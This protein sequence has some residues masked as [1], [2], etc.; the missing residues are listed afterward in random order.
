VV[1]P[2]LSCFK[3]ILRIETLSYWGRFCNWRGRQE[4]QRLIALPGEALLAQ[5]QAFLD[6]LL[7]T[8]KV[9][10][11]T[12]LLDAKWKSISIGGVVILLSC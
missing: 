4:P 11:K 9:T 3:A 6:D 10:I 7:R 2:I 8:L 1:P 5:F 12:S